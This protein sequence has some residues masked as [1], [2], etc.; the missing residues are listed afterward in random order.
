MSPNVFSCWIYSKKNKTTAPLH[1]FYGRTID[2]LGR[3][4]SSMQRYLDLSVQT[5]TGGEEGDLDRKIEQNSA[6]MDKYPQ[7]VEDIKINN[8]DTFRQ[9]HLILHLP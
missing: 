5:F 3:L 7:A 1:S 2:H 6:Q 8:I 4:E 9:I